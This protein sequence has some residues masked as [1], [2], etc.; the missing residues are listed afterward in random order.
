MQ[1][2]GGATSFGDGCKNY[3][4]HVMNNEN[5]NTRDKNGAKTKE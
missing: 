1:H 5:Y 3:K 4:T 2:H